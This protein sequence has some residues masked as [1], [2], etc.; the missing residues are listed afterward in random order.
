MNICVENVNPAFISKSA[1]IVGCSI[2]TIGLFSL[3][4]CDNPT[5]TANEKTPLTISAIL[6]NPARYTA[7]TVS[8]T[9]EYRGWEGGYG[10]PPVTRSDW[11]IKDNTGGMYVTGKAP[12]GF[13]P[14]A[15]R[16]KEVTVTGKVLSKDSRLYIEATNVK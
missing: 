3:I 13:D 6:A 9:G 8:F 4:A 11:I 10:A 12:D 14:Y 16:G 7:Q 5:A 1:I 2:A 15:S